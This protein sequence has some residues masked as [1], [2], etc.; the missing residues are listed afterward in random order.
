MEG[1]PHVP[2]NLVMNASDPC[3]HHP[4][5]K[6]YDTIAFLWRQVDLIFFIRFV[7]VVLLLGVASCSK[8]S[9]ERSVVVY[10]SVD[11]VHA[12]PILREFERRSG[13]AVRAVFDIEAA[14][15]TGLANRLAAEK[16][17]PQ[18][19]LFWNSEFVQTLR[20]KREGVLA[21]SQPRG[22]N[23]LP[24]N[25]RDREGYWYACGARF[26]VILVNTSR[27]PATERPR[28]WEDFASQKYPGADLVIATPFFGTSAD[29]AAALYAAWGRERAR[30]LYT[31]LKQRGVRVVD[32]NSVVRD[33]VVQGVAAAG[34]TDSDDACGAVEKA[35]PVE[36]ILPDQNQ[37]GTLLVPGTVARIAGAPHPA[38]AL[39][40]LEF[41]LEPATEKMLIDSGF[42]Q[43]SAR[44][45][46]PAHSCLGGAE[47]KRM[48]ISLEEIA[49]KLDASGQDMSSIFGQ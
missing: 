44:P 33:L 49:A 13:I 19:D 41:L 11:Q 2:Q 34:W 4:R 21:A 45:G 5:R 14:K 9:P 10:V 42:F 31:Q 16:S 22:A 32:G 26:R 37:Q 36:L 17:R 18:A 23:A 40:L 29:Q 46:G 15:S 12:E 47:V 28:R 7:A 38:E 30:S 39:A 6:L 1:V 25:L 3:R 20:L 24:D 48:S 35:A 27:L 8:T 43:I